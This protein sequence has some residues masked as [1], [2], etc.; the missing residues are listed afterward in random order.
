MSSDQTF[1]GWVAHDK[2]SVNGKLQWGPYQVKPFQETD[3]DVEVECCGICASDLHTLRSGWFPTP[4]PIVVGHEIVGKAT[5]VG[6]EVSG[7][8]YDVPFSLPH[9]ACRE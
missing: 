3:V 1:Q 9:H 5:R 2:D 6:K 4:Y 8:K 7:I